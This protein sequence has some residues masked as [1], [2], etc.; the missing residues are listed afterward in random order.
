M[1]HCPMPTGR[2]VA[3]RPS[4]FADM[5]TIPTHCRSPSSR[6]RAIIDPAGCFCKANH[7]P[8]QVLRQAAA[9]VMPQQPNARQPIE[10]ALEMGWPGHGK[11]RGGRFLCVVTSKECNLLLGIVKKQ[12]C[13]NATIAIGKPL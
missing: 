2:R 10:K 12:D 5:V 7:Q 1:A 11:N 8:R 6:H 3:S 9:I 4:F 13:L